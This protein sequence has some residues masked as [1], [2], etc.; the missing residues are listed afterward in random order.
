MQEPLPTSTMKS[1]SEPDGMKGKAM[2]KRSLSKDLFGKPV[3]ERRPRYEAALENQDEKSRADRAAR[4]RWLSQTIPKN[5]TF[6]T[7][8]ETALVS[9]EATASFVSGNFVAT[10]VLSAAFVEHWLVASLSSR[11]YQKEASQGLGAAI[12]CAMAKNLV[13]P[14]I[15]D[16]V[17]HLR[18]IRN[19][20]VHLKSFDHQYG[21]GQRMAKNRHFDI[22][23]LLEEDAKEAIVAMYGIAIYAFRR[24]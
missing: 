18:L 21:I 23:A 20:F 7:S 8:L 5:L 13:D 16:K 2:S 11:G 12:R 24:K 22:P 4:V 3:R 10:I 14:L 9:G 6:A 19:P 15:L 1:H 17:D